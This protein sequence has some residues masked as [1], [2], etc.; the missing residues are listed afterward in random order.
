[1]IFPR[2]FAPRDKQ[3]RKRPA[4]NYEMADEQKIKKIVRVIDKDVDGNV[5]V[6]HAL[7]KATGIGFMYANAICFVLKLDK[8]RKIGT[9]SK[10]E[11]EKIVDCAKNPE[12]YKIPVWL[13]NRRKDMDTGVDKHLVSSDLMLKKT[14]D[15]RFMRKI[16]SYKGVRHSIGSKKVRGQKTKSTGRK[17]SA[18]GVRRKK[19]RKSGK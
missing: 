11:L 9:F 13:C 2:G 16:K 7:T 4:Q 18:I 10:A 19:S 5:P 8:D 3:R 12:K 17:A 14:F 15:I 6:S 1:M